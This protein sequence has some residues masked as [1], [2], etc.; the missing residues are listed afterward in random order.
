MVV[1]LCSQALHR[2]VGAL[3]GTVA[4]PVMP[5]ILVALVVVAEATLQTRVAQ[6]PLDKGTMVARG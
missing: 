6:E 4:V 2:L 3:A 5:V 1:I